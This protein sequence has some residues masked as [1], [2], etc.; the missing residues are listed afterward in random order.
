MT[1]TA[2]G[3]DWTVIQEVGTYQNG[4][5]I[6][7]WT[8]GDG[9]H[10]ASGTRRALIGCGQPAA[11]LRMTERDPGKWRPATRTYVLC[12][13][14]L[15]HKAREHFGDGRPESVAQVASKKA[16]ER[17]IAD[18]WDE[19]LVAFAQYADEVRGEWLSC[20]P[21]SLRDAADDA[22]RGAEDASPEDVR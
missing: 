18:H 7:P 9:L 2:T 3:D 8:P 10:C 17:I 15:A 5:E 19:Y 22:L 16:R 6:R 20:L 14:H 4:Y 21:K 11:V 12:A 13:L 1:T